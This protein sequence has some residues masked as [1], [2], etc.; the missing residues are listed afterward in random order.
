[1][2]NFKTLFAWHEKQNVSIGD[3][4]YDSDYIDKMNLGVSLKG[5]KNPVAVLKNTK[6]KFTDF[7][8][9][10]SVENIVSEKV[11]DFLEK[12]EGAANFEF[13]PVDFNIKKHPSYFFM[14]I[15]GLVDGFDWEKSDYE[16]YDQLGPKG[17]KMIRNL[18]RME[19]DEAKTAGKRIF[20]L[21]RFI[22]TTY[23]HDSLAKEMQEENITGF[24]SQP[25]RGNN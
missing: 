3:I 2:S 9:S 25:L 11:K 23:V 18:I 5:M 24:K 12:K 6:G 22:G 17:N 21:E 13:Y 1:M 16:L 14:N 8:F 19:I 15:L 7:L 20:L 10:P 4:T